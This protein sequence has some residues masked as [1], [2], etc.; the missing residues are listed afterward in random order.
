MSFLSHCVS[1]R[2]PCPWFSHAPFAFES[3]PTASVNSGRRSKRILS[4]GKPLAYKAIDQ[5]VHDTV[6]IEQKFAFSTTVFSFHL[7]FE[8]L[9][10][11]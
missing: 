5:S 6:V 1:H 4:I 2:I 7:F 9:R 11:P 3:C 8:M 10:V